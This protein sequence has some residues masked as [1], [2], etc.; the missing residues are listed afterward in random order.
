MVVITSLGDRLVF[1]SR[2]DE[3]LERSILAIVLAA[4]LCL[5]GDNVVR[6]RLPE[7]NAVEGGSIADVGE[8]WVDWNRSIFVDIIRLYKEQRA[9]A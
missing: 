4:G 2:S 5:D 6:A 3:L 1:T 9:R 7:A 8:I